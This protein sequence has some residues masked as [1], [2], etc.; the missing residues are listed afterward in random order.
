MRLRARTF[1]TGFAAAALAIAPVT[2]P[3]W[4]QGADEGAGVYG[5]AGCSGCHGANGEGGAGPNLAGNAALSDTAHV[6]QQI[7]AGGGE[8]PPFGDVINDQQ[9]AAVATYIRGT[10]GNTF[11]AVTVEEV[12]AGRAAAGG[13]APAAPAAP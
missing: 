4:G 10:W 5:S 11:P 8:M 2:L 9:I 6:I 13:A 1:A 3:A 7:I 12:T